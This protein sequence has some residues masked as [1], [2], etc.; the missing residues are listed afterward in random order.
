LLGEGCPLYF[1][2]TVFKMRLNDTIWLSATPRTPGSM[3][4][5]EVF[6]RIASMVV[7][8][9]QQG[10]LFRFVNTHL[11]YRSVRAKDLNLKVLFD[12]LQSFPDSLP[13]IIGGDFNDTIS[14]IKP[15]M[16][17]RFSLGL[18]PEHGPTYHDFKGGDGLSQIDHF[19]V[20]EPWQLQNIQVDRRSFFNRLPSDH[21]PVIGEFRYES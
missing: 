5:E 6:P 7:L 20:G 9:H 15:Y 17:R 18:S 19:I 2:R 11:A 21:Y 13:V 14:F 10:P 1:R 16:P 12:F 8:Q 3:D 4:L